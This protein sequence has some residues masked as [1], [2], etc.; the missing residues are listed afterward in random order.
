[1]DRKTVL[2]FVLIG[3][4]LILTQTD[5]YKEKV[6]GLKPG[7]ST[8]DSPVVPDTSTV[9]TDKVPADTENEVRPD[10]QR[11]PDKSQPVDDSKGGSTYVSSFRERLSSV[12]STDVT[13]ETNLYTA[14]ISGKGATVV[15]WRLKNYFYNSKDSVSVQMIT[16]D[17]YGNLG[18]SFP[19]GPDTLQTHT[20]N[21]KADKT[22]IN[23]DDGAESESV[24]FDLEFEPG[25]LL[26]KTYTFYRDE[27]AFDLAIELINISNLISEQKYTLYWLS[28]LKYTEKHVTED[29]ANA[30]AYI[31]TAGGKEELRL[32]D[33]P[34][35]KKSIDNI[36]GQIEWIGI[37]T[38][39][40]A[41]V[42]L[43]I[44]KDDMIARVE[45]VTR[46]YQGKLMHK[47]YSAFL[48]VRASA[49]ARDEFKIYIGPLD[50]DIVKTYHPGFDKIMGYGPAIIR[51]FA[52][53]TLRVFKFLHSF[54][55]NYGV[56]LIIFAILV[57]LVV[58]P[59][60]KKSYTSMREMQK[61]QP[62]MAALKE[63]YSKDPQRLNSE[64]M[65]LYKEHGVNPMS[66]CLPMLLQMPLLWSVFL[67]FRNT[68]Q[69]RQASFVLW[70]D[71]LSSP[72]TIAQLPFSLPLLGSELHIIPLIMGVTMFMQQKMTMT[73][74][75]QKAMMYFMPLFLTVLFY[76]FP[77]GLNIY[78]TLFNIF[79]IIQQR[80]TTDG[81]VSQPVAIEKTTG[82][83]RSAK[84]SK[85]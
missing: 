15:S 74:P 84:K 44:S 85:K 59:L 31:F 26:R 61:L 1:M 19:V 34:N 45:G 56:V 43:P 46:P 72:D 23:L 60:T 62:L 55:P 28:G 36:E 24:V 73:D 48:D 8:V 7:Q 76:S 33:K 10:A 53:L 6:L 38:K 82:K 47:V 13:V 64:T 67:V 39:Y 25:K 18:V 49:S 77:S 27:Y 30:K 57:K 2:A 68:I 66:G 65:K 35:V 22:A 78:Y 3:F 70:I 12:E 42:M 29:I 80:L 37:R 21:F 79:T 4:L 5:W 16:D 20:L 11:E 83:A 9:V 75:K 32:S 71:D 51:P 54:I 40:F 14:E 81:N 50:Y 52:K 41:S 69:L 17:A 63:K 58:Y